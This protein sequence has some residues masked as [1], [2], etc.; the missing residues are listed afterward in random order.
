MLTATNPD[1]V[2]LRAA[3]RNASLFLLVAFLIYCSSFV[4]SSEKLSE[5]LQTAGAAGTV[6]GLADWFAV[7]AL[8]RR[9]LGLPIPHTALIPIEKR[10]KLEL[11]LRGLLKLAFLKKRILLLNFDQKMSL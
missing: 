7:T 8:F 2:K 6:G 5:F 3:K 11:Q 9:P 4:V 1:V 10:T